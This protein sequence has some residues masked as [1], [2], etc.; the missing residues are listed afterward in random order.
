ML[1]YFQNLKNKKKLGVGGK[2][3]HEHHR[4]MVLTTPSLDMVPL[5]TFV[6]S[7]CVKLPSDTWAAEN[8]QKPGDFEVPCTSSLGCI[9][10]NSHAL[11]YL[12]LRRSL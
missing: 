8:G 2:D 5:T 1:S 4:A 9:L 6:D 10:T 12:I 7:A 3:R 11:S